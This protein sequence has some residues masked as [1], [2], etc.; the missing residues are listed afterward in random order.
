MSCRGGTRR[1]QGKGE[2]EEQGQGKGWA[3]KGA[4]SQGKR[5][6]PKCAFFVVRDRRHR[7]VSDWWIGLSEPQ[8]ISSGQGLEGEP[9]GVGG[10]GCQVQRHE[11]TEDWWE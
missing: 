7:A 11:V 10:E 8:G 9:G 6:T 4:A 3:A 2:Q 5:D 1:L